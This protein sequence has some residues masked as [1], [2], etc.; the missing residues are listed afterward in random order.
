VPDFVREYDVSA[1]AL[2]QDWRKRKMWIRDVVRLGDPT[3]IDEMLEGLKQIIPNAWYEYKTNPNPS[4]KIASLKL[5][6]D[7]YID[8]I[9]LLQ[10][11]GI[12]VK[13][14]ERLEVI[15]PWLNKFVSPATNTN[16][17]RDSKNSTSTP[18]D[19]ES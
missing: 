8:I 17:I 12:I 7:T 19:S 15:A 2:Y 18:Q 11:L 4:V 6:K 10:S 3:L 14:P 13:V 5:A 1:Q 16:H 9:E